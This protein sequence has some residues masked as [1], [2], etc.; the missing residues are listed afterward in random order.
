MASNA[1]ISNSAANT[2]KIVSLGLILFAVTAIT[3]IILGVVH[4]ITLEPIRITQERLKVEALA[5]SLPEADS[6]SPVE[7]VSDSD[8]IVKDVQE[9][10]LGG[11]PAGFCLTV[12][13]R[14]YGGL[15]E[16]VIGITKTGGVRAIRILSQNETPGLGAKAANPTFYLQYE[17]KIAPV[18]SVV[19]T[20]PTAPNQIQAISGATITSN[21]V[22][23][24]VNTALSYW[25][26]N[27]AE[28]HP[29]PDDFDATSAA[30]QT[31]EEE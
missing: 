13:P 19:K 5:G 29:L 22:T 2:K 28:G 3:G 15:V 1:T 27:L 20:D 12:A 24:G 21:A 9:A 26:K 25:R 18:L 10:K 16:I 23:L 11:E 6:F 30:T 14:G 31:T 4:D 8:P 7:L 17:N